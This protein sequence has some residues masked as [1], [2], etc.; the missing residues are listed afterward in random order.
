[1]RSTNENMTK[2]ACLYI[3][4]FEKKTNDFEKSS[5]SNNANRM[6]F[7][8]RFKTNQKVEKANENVRKKKK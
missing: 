2:N 1:M 7:R 3:Q 4:V 5:T 8:T 6:K